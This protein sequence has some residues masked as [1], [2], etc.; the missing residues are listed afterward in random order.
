M[1]RRSAG[2][3]AGVVL[4]AG[5]VVGLGGRPA[6]AASTVRFGYTGSA[7]AYVVPDGVT[8]LTVDVVGAS[9]GGVTAAGCCGGRGGR[10]FAQLAVTPGETL[11]VVVGG[12]GGFNGGAAGGWS[13]G[14]HPYGRNGGGASDVRQGG[15]SLADRVIVAGGGG[16]SGGGT[17]GT[18]D[19]GDGGGLPG[20]DGYVSTTYAGR[21]GG[22]GGPG[23]VVTG[24]YGG[25]ATCYGGGCLPGLPGSSGAGGAGG[26]GSG[27]YDC[28]GGNGGGGGGGGYYGGGG[29]GG[30]DDCFSSGA[31]GGGGSSYAGPATR[32]AALTPGYQV[33]DGYVEVTV[34]VLAPS[35]LPP[36]QPP[37]VP[38]L[39]SPAYG[40]EVSTDDALTFAIRATD[41]DQDAYSGTVR[42]R[43]ESSGELVATV[44]TGPAQ[45][46]QASP[47]RTARLAPGRYTWT[48]EA[49]DAFGATGPKS[50]PRL[51]VVSAADDPL[52]AA[53]DS[54]GGAGAVAGTFFYYAPLDPI[55]SWQY[56]N[57]LLTVA[58]S[59]ANASGATF[60]GCAS[61]ELYGEGQVGVA[62][63]SEYWYAALEDGGCPAATTGG[64][65]SPTISGDLYG[66]SARIGTQLVMTLSGTV[67]IAR[68][69][70]GEATVVVTAE[71]G[72]V[73]PSGAWVYGSWT[74]VSAIGSGN[75][76]PSQPTALSPVEGAVVSATTAPSFVVQ[77]GDTEGDRYRG[78]VRVRDGTGQLV[79][80]AIGDE[81]DSGATATATLPVPLPP[82][83]YTWTA[84]AVDAAGRSS[85][86]SAPQSFTAA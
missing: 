55:G 58:G 28:G 45:S 24:G 11:S 38:T 16:G 29:G 33:G 83:R 3:V 75:V 70:C 46:G 39:D 69:A 65:G 76:P 19:G 57:G 23:T 14:S 37:L 51:L 81:A 48:A 31:G 12:S 67:C 20:E 47:G 62:I 64:D 60:T 43:T 7:Q 52:P 26:R 35:L 50:A 27:Y 82:G 73:P 74:A 13:Y 63:A 22:G 1:A 78:Y 10:V 6:A 21:G 71:F 4:I 40:A 32:G 15:S 61:L 79:A 86:P 54:G 53:P 30:G 8:V 5:V 59:L 2:W 72:L 56:G 84:V 66:S 49:A 18:A 44:P 41:P 42:V 25:S 80:V 68:T 85:A 34:G 9:G 17:I 77:A 36:N